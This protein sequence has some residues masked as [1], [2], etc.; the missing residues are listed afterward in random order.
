[1]TRGEALWVLVFNAAIAIYG[2]YRGGEYHM[3]LAGV[4]AMNVG[5][6]MLTCAVWGKP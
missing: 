5:H 6:A 1:M 4:C 3:F 2:L